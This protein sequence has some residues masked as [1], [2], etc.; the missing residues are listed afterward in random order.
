MYLCF[1]QL[2]VFSKFKEVSL[3]AV[4]T[5]VTGLSVTQVLCTTTPKKKVSSEW[6]LKEKL[7]CTSSRLLAKFVPD[8]LETKAK[9]GP[10]KEKSPDKKE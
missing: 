6:A 1:K 9:R 5:H 8:K 10:A 7:K 4:Q 2:L 3:G